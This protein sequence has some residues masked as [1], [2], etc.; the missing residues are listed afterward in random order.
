[1]KILNFVIK[2]L[3]SSNGKKYNALFII[4][5]DKENPEKLVGYV[6]PKCIRTI[7]VDSKKK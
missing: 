5:D 1:M 3:E 4:T 2:E 6:N 7:P